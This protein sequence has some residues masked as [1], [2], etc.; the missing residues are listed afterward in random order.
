MSGAAQFV[1]ATI[2]GGLLLG[3]IGGHL[4]NPVVL[5]RA[6]DEPWRDMLEADTTAADN[7]ATIEAPPQD[8]HPYGGRYSY[9]PAFADEA[10]EAWPDPYI[11]DPYLDAEW[12][13]HEENWPEPPTIAELDARWAEWEARNAEVYGR[14]VELPPPSPVDSIAAEAEHVVD[15]AEAAADQLRPLSDTLPPEPHVADGQLPAIW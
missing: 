5:Q 13:E 1:V 12:L 9:A 10:I 15:E 3:A 2:G 8:L 14:T 4:A 11:S 7:G 6:G